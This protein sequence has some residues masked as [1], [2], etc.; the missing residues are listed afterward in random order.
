MST[1]T[2]FNFTNLPLSR[3]AL[4]ERGTRR[5]Q[6]RAVAV[7]TAPAPK[8]NDGTTYTVQRG[9]TLWKI[10]TKFSTTVDKL[11]KL[12]GLTGRRAKSL[13]VGQTIAVRES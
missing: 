6:G 13:Q 8:R 5:A 7:A 1:F 11:R 2:R 10:A 9:D 12:N 3:K 4:S